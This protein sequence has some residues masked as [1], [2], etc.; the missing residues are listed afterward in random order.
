MRTT[1][2][3]E[4]SFQGVYCGFMSYGSHLLHEKEAQAPGAAKGRENNQRIG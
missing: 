4:S 2:R 3:D 1:L